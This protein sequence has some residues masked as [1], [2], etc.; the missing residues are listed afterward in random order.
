MQQLHL[1]MDTLAAAYILEWGV[2]VGFVRCL[3]LLSLSPQLCVELN[4]SSISSLFITMLLAPFLSDR[5]Y[6]SIFRS[7]RMMFVVM[8]KLIS[9]IGCNHLYLPLHYP[10]LDVGWN[11]ARK[12][13]FWSTR[14]SVPH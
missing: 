14:L 6:F 10:T 8:N 4:S 3:F 7:N 2:N 9:L 11:C 5:W 12:K 1:S 13:H